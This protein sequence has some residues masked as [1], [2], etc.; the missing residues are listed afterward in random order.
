MADTN[1]D[2]EAPIDA[3]EAADEAQFELMM[4]ESVVPATKDTYRYLS[5]FFVENLAQIVYFL[6][7]CFDRVS[8][9]TVEF[10]K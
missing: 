8:I 4:G 2:D 5:I 3:D 6:H 9:I 10:S 1:P 7:F